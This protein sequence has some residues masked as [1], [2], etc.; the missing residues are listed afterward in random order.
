[1]GVKIQDRC[2][3]LVDDAYSFVKGVVESDD[4]SLNISRET[5][6]RDRQLRFIAKQINKKIKD[7]LL[8]M[9]KNKRDDY[10]AFFKE[11]GNTIKM[12]IYESYAMNKEDLEDLLMFYS[13][14]E[15]KLISLKEYKENMA[16]TEEN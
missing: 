4:I 16:S 11:F 5:L 9:Q 12:A 1:H 10:D 6:Q 2:E 14:K 3:D 7:H 15:D 8:D 13:R